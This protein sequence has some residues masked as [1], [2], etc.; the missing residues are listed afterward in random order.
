[1]EKKRLFLFFIQNLFF[2]NIELCFILRKKKIV[3]DNI[4]QLLKSPL[5][6]A[7]LFMDD[8]KKGGNTSKGM[9][10]NFSG[11]DNTNQEK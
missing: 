1:M 2:P 11:F 7:T 6:L 10:F 4:D 8:G 5:T 9:V 3:P